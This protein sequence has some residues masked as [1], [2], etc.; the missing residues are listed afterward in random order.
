MN[1]IETKPYLVGM[2]SADLAKLAEEIG[3]FPFR[4]KQLAEWIYRKSAT[5][6]DEMT[7]LPADM[8]SALAE[9]FSIHPLVLVKE[10]RSTD[11]VIKL[12]LNTTDAQG[13][14]AVLMDCEGQRISSCISSQVGCAM[15]CTFCATGLGGFTRSLNAGEIVDQVLQLQII[16]GKRIDHVSFMG[17]GEPLLNL[18]PVLDAARIFHDELGISYRKIHISTVGIVPKIY[19]LAASGLPIHLAVSLH[20]PTND[21]RS[22]FMPV[23]RKWNVGELLDAAREYAERTGRKITFEYLMMDGVNDSVEEAARLGKAIKGIPCFVNLIP[24][25]YVDTEPGFRRPDAQ[26][27]RAFKAEL[28]RQGI[29]VSQR[30]E[31]GHGIDAAC[32]QL[33]GKHL[34]N[35]GRELAAL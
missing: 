4:A 32:G 19:E 8:R 28:V 5:S 18:E 22:S 2:S 12:L 16:S 21:V 23:N 13:V 17:M 9:R 34:G 33:R 20:S 15:G 31:R 25:N 30:K 6:F 35:P 29:A 7:D 27:V 1:S 24:F 26:R 10:Q 3:A 11:G 14:E